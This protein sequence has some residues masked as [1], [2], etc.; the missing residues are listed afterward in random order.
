M[1]K[2]ISF[3]FAAF[4]LPG[5]FLLYSQAPDW[6]RILQ[7]SSVGLQNANVVTSDNNY[8][9]V[10]GTICGPFTFGGAA[11]TGVGKQDM[12]VSK[13]TNSGVVSWTRQFKA[14]VG[15]FILPN[16][17]AVDV[18]SN[19]YITGF[20]T[21]SV[22]IGSKTV[23][24][25][26]LNNAFIAKLDPNGNG[27]WIS[28]FLSNGSG[29]TKIAVDASGNSYVINRG[30]K[31]MKF[32]NSGIPI[33]E[34]NYPLN[35]LQAIAVKGS[36]LFIGGAL[37]QG[38]TSFGA[39][40]LSGL[41]YNTA[42]LARADLDG[43]FN[44]TLI[45]STSSFSTKD[46]NYGALGTFIHP[47]A[48][49]R[50]I[51]LTK[52]VS[53]SSENVLT[54]SV[55]DLAST[56]GYVVLTINPANDSVS[57]SGLVGT[58]QPVYASGINYYN[59]GN[60]TFTLHY[61]Y[62][63][64][65]GGNARI[66]S[67]ELTK[68][69]D[70]IPGQSSISDIAFDINGDMIL[71]GGFTQNLV[72]DTISI[73]NS[74][75]AN[76]T[77][78]AKCNSNL[79]FAWIKPSQKFLNAQLYNFR[80]FVDA[81]NNIYESAP[82][83][84]SS[85]TYGSVTVPATTGQFL[86]QFDPTGNAI[87]AFAMQNNTVNRF[88]LTP[89]GK[90]INIGS[91]NFAGAPSYG[92]VYVDQYYGDMSLEWRQISSGITSGS[93][94][95][96]SVKHDPT[97]NIYV[98]AKII[99]YY[100]YLGTIINSNTYVTIIAKH[101]ITGKLLWLKQVSDI[102]PQVFGTSFTLDKDNNVLFVGLFNSSLIV[103]STT[104]TS[105]NTG[106]EGYV[107]KF[108]TNGDFMWASKM[109]LSSDVTANITLTTDNAG[110]V[111]VSGV[112]NPS[113]YLVKFDPLGNQLWAK[114]IP[115]ESYYLS[116]VSTD[117][118]NNIYMT[119]EI[120]LTAPIMIG[121][122]PLTQ[123]FEDGSIALVKFDPNG[124]ALWAKTYGG[125][126][127]ATYSDGWPCA[128]RND[129]AGNTILW[130]TFKNNAI[131]GAA[132]LTNPLSTY[133]SLGQDYSYYVTKIN[134]SGAVLWVKPIFE[135]KIGFNYGDLMD[136]DKSGN[137]YVGGH[138]KDT[139]SIDGSIYK[140]EGT[141]D[142]FMSKYSGNGDFQWITTIPSNIEIIRGLCVL[143]DDVVTITGNA[144]I[145]P[146]LGT[147]AII[148]GTGTTSIIASLGSICYA[149]FDFTWTGT[150][151]F[152]DQSVGNPTAWSWDFGDGTYSTEQNPVHAYSKSGV[153]T[154]KLT[155]INQ[156]SNCVAS[157]NRKVTAGAVTLCQSEFE[158]VLNAVS[159]QTT[160]TSKSID[161]TEYYWNFGDGIF[162]T[163]MNPSHTFA[164]AG[165]YQVCLTI[166]NST[167]ACQSVSC[168]DVIYIPSGENYIQADF[169]YYIDP[170]GTSVTF[171]D[172]A[173]SNTTDWYWTFG[174]GKVSKVKDP[175][176]TYAKAGVY[177]V[178]LTVFDKLNSLSQ[179]VCKEVRVGSSSCS[180]RSDF[181]YFINPVAREVEFYS[182]AKGVVS[183]YFWIFGDGSSSAAENP[184]HY[185]AVP[186]VY[187]ITLMVRS[188][189]ENCIDK[190]TQV[191]QV[192]SVDCRAG[193]TYN[194]DSNTGTAFFRDD[195]KGGIDYYYWDMGD[196]AF[197][198]EKDP[199]HVYKKAGIYMV[200][201]TVIDNINGCMDL[202]V[203]PIQLG[204]VTCA[205]DF[206]TYV[207]SLNYTAYFTNRTLGEST[208]FLWSFG[209]GKFSTQQNPVHTFPG[210]GM[211]SAGLNTYNFDNGC[212]DYYE[213]MLIIGGIGKDCE[214]DFIY[215]VDQS[216]TEVSF[217]NNSL[218]D[219]SAT[220]WN[221]GDQTLNSFEL[222]P[223]HKYVSAGY[224]NVCLGVI[225]SDGIKNMNCKWILVQGDDS[226]DCLA[227][228]M[229]TVDSAN[230]KVNFADNSFGNIDS[231]TWDFGDSKTDSISMLQ[232]PEHTYNQKG[233]YMVRLKVEN[234]VSNCSSKEYKLLN[235]GELQVLKAA[236]S[237]EAF[238]PNKKV[239]GYPVDLVS[240]SSGDGATVEWDFGDK[241]EK[242]GPFTT[243]DSTSR[244]VT[245]YYQLPG[246][247]TV[248]L[249]V[250]DPVS[251]QFDEYCSLVFTKGFVGL[252]ENNVQGV[253]L[254]VYPNPFAEFTTINYSLPHAQY[255]EMQIFDQLGRR[256]QTLVKSR[257]DSG[258]HQVVFE[259]KN[260]LPGV[261][262]LK[263]VTETDNISRQLVITR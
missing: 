229:F 127:G 123:T 82:V 193:F 110:N 94:Q 165:I 145:K 115:M 252:D 177:N 27:L 166:L 89:A 218:G 79:E 124:N 128:I 76:Y 135:K 91:Y 87:N 158:Y 202:T 55:G 102:S 118:G 167:N 70:F 203:L 17:I 28:S 85:F 74:A 58:Q 119:T 235:V 262:T 114:T 201:Q 227:N 99:G 263:V 111:I 160:F 198:V 44:K 133:Q 181:S 261:Y 88:S 18:A 211:Y 61:S 220:V 36:D 231:Y 84:N 46:G 188:N 64:V 122:V 187:N 49:V 232:N 234:T 228:F 159:G 22:T 130:G 90:F 26:A 222:D 56:N 132:T 176:Y 4:L 129:A 258:D 66:I 169:S 65:G 254:D 67:E 92:N 195:S 161:A 186:G 148:T 137:I 63:A 147:K 80:V 196:G 144:G 175:V 2:L 194:I 259:S 151:N 242:K 249:R 37:Q 42:F 157:V 244:I 60:K 171:N 106:S 204:E 183:S 32:S 142:F 113:N 221:F 11:F 136:L 121:S 226:N 97:G 149:Q 23:T 25:D 248:C 34:Q 3:L 241:Q 230:L 184:R 39:F 125:V 73:I 255:V 20:F 239:T 214:A 192:G 238:E 178:C 21:G 246:K 71:T 172:L 69:S 139:I 43:I 210:Q 1:K 5:H 217:K 155:T 138:F 14:G 62:D 243:M 51:N 245:H 212:M 126:I 48:G 35:T 24:A 72:L 143:K 182:Q 154:V 156:T 247:Y 164:K 117:A 237:Y 219:I 240:A 45:E 209:D 233:Y 216:K 41:A 9:Y 197:S 146:T 105:P 16:A 189:V 7:S 205:A 78:I 170:A 152:T 59:P 57:I 131:F 30:N 134:P 10:A 33:W 215:M 54:T 77:F 223:V 31:L 257:N 206:I 104:L 108:S 103:G 13:I 213:E 191:I 200:S 101:D 86:V 190:Y 98:H 19:T 8:V 207:D 224:Y 236:F 107:A 75:P 40:N 251:G 15:L 29:N 12:F 174:D 47:T 173:S 112:I 150:G 179:S 100:D 52:T 50:T 38:I 140:P 116:L 95:T 162:S 199:D 260:L 83:T 109:N 168:K 180:I 208:S 253:K 81:A 141:N 185:F 256:I 153:Y 68:Q 96:N 120:H 163:E 250:T 93:M 225:N 53:G 6:T